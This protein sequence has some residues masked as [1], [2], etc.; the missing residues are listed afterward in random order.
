MRLV[1]RALRDLGRGILIGRL[2][3]LPQAEQRVARRSGRGIQRQPTADAVRGALE[4]EEHV[5]AR[6]RGG[7]AGDGCRDE[8]VAVA[9]AADP[10]PDAH[11]R[12]HHGRAP[13]CRGS[14]QRV[15]HAAVDVRDR[16]V[17]SLVEHGHHGADL[18]GGRGLLGSQRS[19]APER[20]DLLEHPTL[21]A[22]LVGAVAQRRVVL[23]EERREAPDARRD[24]A[25]PGLGGVRGEHRVE[26]QRLQ[27][28]ERGVIAHLGSQAH[29]RG[30]DRVGR[31][32]AVG[33]TVALPQD[34]HALVLL[35]EVHEVEVAR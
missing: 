19:G 22:A 29:E 30:G 32:L 10:R 31:I 1:R 34:A 3:P 17:Q 13:A 4:A 14:L 20:V 2:E 5:L 21:G 12:A 24:R 15:V 35:R 23:L 25:P 26:A 11:E 28:C 18:V 7:L 6:D 9:V 16:G 27:T 8:R 33:A